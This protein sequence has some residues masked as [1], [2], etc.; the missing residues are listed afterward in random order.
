MNQ[1]V[2]LSRLQLA[3]AIAELIVWVIS[4]GLIITIGCSRQ[5]QW[6]CMLVNSSLGREE[7]NRL[8]GSRAGITRLSDLNMLW[9]TVYIRQVIRADYAKDCDYMQLIVLFYDLLDAAPM[10][11]GCWEPD[12]SQQLLANVTYSQ[13]RS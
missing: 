8:M 3:C 12:Q 13:S 11:E 7:E 1:A 5:Q 6:N 10:G 4:L 9:I 2:K